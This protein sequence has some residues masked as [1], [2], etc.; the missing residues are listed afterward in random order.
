MELEPANSKP[1][2]LSMGHGDIG[3]KIPA[4]F[5]DP[6]RRRVSGGLDPLLL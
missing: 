3:G 2:L 1:A 4:L 5:Q 6:K